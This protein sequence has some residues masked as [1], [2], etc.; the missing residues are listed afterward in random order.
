MPGKTTRKN[1]NALTATRRNALELGRFR[2]RVGWAE[3]MGADPETV[4]IAAINM[5]GAPRANI[6]ARD[7]LTPFMRQSYALIG[8]KHRTAVLMTNK[9]KD[10]EPVLQELAATLRDGLKQAVRDY[11]AIPNAESTIDRKGFDDPLVGAGAD[12]GRIVA[13]AN[14]MVKKR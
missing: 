8:R 4:K 12:G 6:P 10:P 7:V 1:P 2:V 9:G 5:L 11:S 13:E 14:A 3:D